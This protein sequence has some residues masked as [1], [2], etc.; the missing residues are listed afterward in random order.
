MTQR[1]RPGDRP[2]RGPLRPDL[3]EGGGPN[4]LPHVSLIAASRRTC[5]SIVRAITGTQIHHKS[6]TNVRVLDG[7]E[8]SVSISKTGHLPASS[9]LHLCHRG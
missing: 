8:V 3:D 6:V 9:D 5:V 2:A 7:T 4:V 1:R